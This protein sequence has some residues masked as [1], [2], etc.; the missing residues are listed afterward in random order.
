M[1]DRVRHWTPRYL[2]DRLALMVY[3]RRNPDGPW[4]TRQMIGILGDWLKPDDRGLEWGA[5]RSTVWLGKRIAQL[6]T[7]EDNT[8]WANRVESILSQQVFPGHVELK[9]API[10]EADNRQPGASNY[11]GLG[12]EIA[13]SSLDFVLVDGALRDHCAAVGLDKLKSGGILIID[14]VERYIPRINKSHSPFARGIS[15]GFGTAEWEL[16][17]RTV[18]NWRCVWTSNGVTDTAF[19]VKP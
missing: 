8:D 15:D 18:K 7:I 9:L 14:N 12:R 2:Y 3:E 4:L 10:T 5:G 1:F 16:V 11:V 19:W 13:S 6:T 17:F